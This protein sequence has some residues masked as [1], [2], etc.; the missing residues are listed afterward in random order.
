M[1]LH[2]AGGQWRQLGLSLHMIYYSWHD[3][4]AFFQE[5]KRGLKVQALPLEVKQCHLPQFFWP[6]QVTRTT[7]S[8]SREN[9]LHLLM[10]G[11]GKVTL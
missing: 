5:G 4:K 6:K 9:N 1:Q 8:K 3:S 2:S 10:G 11:L 7:H